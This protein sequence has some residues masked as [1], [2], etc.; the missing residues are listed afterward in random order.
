MKVCCCLQYLAY[1]IKKEN[2]IRALVHD[3][4]YVAMVCIP[5]V[6]MTIVWS[7]EIIL[8]FISKEFIPASNI[9]K[10]L[11]LVALVKVLNRPWSVALEAQTGQFLSI[12]S[13]VV[14]F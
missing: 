12:L 14:R 7:S 8:V 2:E 11:A 9:L 1:A 6:V 13:I 4:R 3:E 5:V 10:I